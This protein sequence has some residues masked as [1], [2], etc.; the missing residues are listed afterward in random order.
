MTSFFLI[1]LEKCKLANVSLIQAAKPNW[2]TIANTML[3]G[4]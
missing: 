3:G 2:L 1:N 4:I